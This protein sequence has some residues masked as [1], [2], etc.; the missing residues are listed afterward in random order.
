METHKARDRNIC[1]SN[2]FLACW[3]L[4]TRGKSRIWTLNVLILAHFF[5]GIDSSVTRLLPEHKHH[6]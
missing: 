6:Y 4:T 5:P 3:K 1:S 2:K